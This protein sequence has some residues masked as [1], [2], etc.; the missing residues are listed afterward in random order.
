[1]D[2]HKR[3]RHLRQNMTRAERL[4]WSQLKARRLA[5]HKFRRQH[6]MDGCIADFACLQGKLIVEVDGGCHDDSTGVDAGRTEW[7]EG[8]GFRVVRFDN[9][10]VLHDLDGVLARIRQ[11]LL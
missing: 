7:L 4:L 5:G 3:A 8:E 10:E 2:L 1:M 11:A 6:V 9:D